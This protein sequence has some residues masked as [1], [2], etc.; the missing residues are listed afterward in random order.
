MVLKYTV[1]LLVGLYSSR[2]AGAI[3]D[4]SALRSRDSAST[5]IV[6]RVRTAPHHPVSLTANNDRAACVRFV[7]YVGHVWGPFY[8]PFLHSDVTPPCAS[9]ESRVHP[10]PVS[11]PTHAATPVEP[12]PRHL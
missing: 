4:P 8:L 5:S 2:V 7:A 6:A 3:R 11:I 12:A 9:V 10:P 1:Q